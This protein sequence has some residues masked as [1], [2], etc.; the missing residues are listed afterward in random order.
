MNELFDV[1]N[2]LEKPIYYTDTDSLHCNFADIPAIETEYEKRYNKVLTGTALEQF[3]TDFNLKGAC[4]EIYATKS[5]FLGKKSY[6]DLL[7]STDKDGKT[8]TG[9]H[10]RL[11]GIT[12]AG[13]EHTAK[14][15]SEDK[16]TPE[17][18]KLYEDL[19]QGTKKKDNP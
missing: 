18:F 1:A 9:Y 7:E 5:I 8:I 16:K 15:Y 14:T 17:Y 10:I 2:D 19:A 12:E 6:I 11:K 3:H 13:L 4:S